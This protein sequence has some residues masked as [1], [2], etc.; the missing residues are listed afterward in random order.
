MQY[1]GEFPKPPQR[2]T[3]KDLLAWVQ[4]QIAQGWRVISCYE[5]GP[6]GYVLHRQLTALGVT[7]YVIR[8]RNWDDQHQRVK[9]DR[10]DA[11]AMLNAL[12]RFVAGNP[13][14]LAVGAGADRSPGTAAQRKPAAAESAAGLENDCA[15]G[16]RAG[17][18]IR[19]PVDGQ[20]VWATELAAVAGAGVVDRVV[21]AVADGG[22]G[23]AR[24]GAGA[25]GEDRSARARNPSPK[26][27]AH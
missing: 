14:A 22:A 15:T 21:D 18:A 16:T 27:W 7:N 23:V 3:P 24:T 8:P 13:H 5:A 19:L 25:D 26:A 17:V 1:D 9:T 20:M 4:K 10:T 12:D 6:F 2:F 11:R